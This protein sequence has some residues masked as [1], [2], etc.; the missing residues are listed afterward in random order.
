MTKFW[1]AIFVAVVANVIANIAIKK[2]SQQAPADYPVE[3]LLQIISSAW[4]WLFGIASGVLVLS[5]IYAV[6]GV[7]L[8]IAYSAVSGLALLLITLV[9]RYLFH[10]TLGF[11]D[12]VGMALIFLGVVALSYSA[13]VRT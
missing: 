2:T 4:F 11:F 6:R 1:I 3:L 13:S 7:P 8:P 9:S 10:S 5:Y 12:Y